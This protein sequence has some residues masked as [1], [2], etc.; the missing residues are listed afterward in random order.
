M[1]EA[2]GEGRCCAC[3]PWSLTHQEINFVRHD[4]TA[5]LAGSNSE[6][7]TGEVYKGSWRLL[8]I[9]INLFRSWSTRDIAAFSVV[10]VEAV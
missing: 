7:Q 9:S 10:E 8:A 6:K 3:L 5:Q 4:I 2:S 1:F